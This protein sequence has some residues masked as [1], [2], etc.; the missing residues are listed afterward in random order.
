VPLQAVAG[1]VPRQG[2]PSAGLP[3]QFTQ[4]GAHVYLQ[5]PLEQVAFVTNA[6]DWQLTQAVPHADASLI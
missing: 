5:V 1:L 6:S 2:H 3:L 4:F